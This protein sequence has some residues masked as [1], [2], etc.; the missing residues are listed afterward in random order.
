MVIWLVGGAAA[1]LFAACTPATRPASFPEKMAFES[2][3]L[4]SR[5]VSGPDGAFSTVILGALQRPMRDMEDGAGVSAFVDIGSEAPVECTFFQGDL[6]LASAMVEFSERGFE[7]LTRHFGPI[8]SKQP[9][10]ISAGAIGDSPTLSLSW[11]YR[12]GAETGLIKH[13]I[14]SVNGHGLY[15]RHAETGYVKTFARLFET[16]V[17]HLERRD[18]DSPEAF[19]TVVARTKLRGRPRGVEKLVATEVGDETV[20]IESR[21]SMLVASLYGRLSA[22][23]SVFVRFVRRDG[24]LINAVYARSE[25]GAL[26]TNLSLDPQSAG[27]AIAGIRNGLPYERQIP[28]VTALTSTLGE[29][30]SLRATMR[31]QGTGGSAETRGW[32]PRIDP[33]DLATQVVILGPRRDPDH[34][35]VMSQIG[36]VVVESVV[37][38]TGEAQWSRWLDAKIGVLETE[39]LFRAGRF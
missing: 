5:A 34:F 27:W 2:P 7:K 12:V 31:E 35:H 11:R 22:V 14:G 29:V 3:D 4:P 8:L 26:V 20:R 24:S 30:Q 37:D 21:S 15:C 1:I 6:D 13:R 33:S 32:Y 39:R 36:S 17:Q 28:G 23:D 16:I 38:V 9:H 19:Y 10:T 18:V 25:D